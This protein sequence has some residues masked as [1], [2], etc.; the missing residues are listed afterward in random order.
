MNKNI[1]PWDNRAQELRPLA[2]DKGWAH[3]QKELA[4]DFDEFK[5]LTGEQ[6]RSKLRRQPWYYS[7]TKGN[8]QYEDKKQA[9]SEDVENLIAAVKGLQKA[10]QAVDKKQ[11]AINL[12]LDESKPVAIAAWGDWHLGGAGTDYNK[13]EEH[14]DIIANTDGLYWIGMG[15]YKDNYLPKMPF[16]NAEQIIPSGTQDLYVLTEMQK[17]GHN[18]L[19]LVRGCHDDWDMHNANKDFVQ[20]LCD[21]IDAVN[22][23]HGGDLRITLNEQE[24][25][26]KCRHKYKF[27]SS[28][29]KSNAMRRIMEQQGACDVALSAHLHDPYF[30]MSYL[31]GAWRVLG[32]SGSYKKWDEHGQKLAGYKGKSGVPCII[33]HP[34]KKRMIPMYLDDAVDYL[35]H[36]RT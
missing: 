6:T 24:Y 20:F 22:L 29:N 18:C 9:T 27:E 5:G 26:F 35:K 16:G 31:M 33:L 21:K 32:R 30:Y 28:L 15:D 34:D 12:T 2:K 23:W 36:L 4:K 13:F 14:R 17:V 11:V 19:A 3:I 1:K 8:I 10:N 7:E 25:H